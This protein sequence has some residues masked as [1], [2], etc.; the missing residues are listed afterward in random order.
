MKFFPLGFEGISYNSV[1]VWK[2]ASLPYVI[3]GGIRKRQHL[4]R[5]W[6]GGLEK[7][8]GGIW[9]PDITKDQIITLSINIHLARGC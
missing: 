3:Q 6:E 1:A 4:S 9:I 5:D 8:K 7:G 2:K